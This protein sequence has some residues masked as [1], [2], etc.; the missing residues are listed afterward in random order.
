MLISKNLKPALLALA[1]F[2][3][4]I[5]SF[6]QVRGVIG[7]EASERI[8]QTLDRTAIEG[9]YLQSLNGVAAR[10]RQYVIDQIESIRAAVIDFTNDFNTNP[11]GLRAFSRAAKINPAPNNKNLPSHEEFAIAVDNFTARLSNLRLKLDTIDAIFNSLPSKIE[12]KDMRGTRD[13][14]VGDTPVQLE[15]NMSKVKET[16]AQSLTDLEEQAKNLF[17]VVIVNNA[18]GKSPSQAQPVIIQA[19]TGKS[20]T[21]ETDLILISED[22]RKALRA[23]IRMLRSW[24]TDDRNAFNQFTEF[25]AN[26][27]TRF[28]TK[29]GTEES[30]RFRNDADMKLREEIMGSL[31]KSFF[32]RSRYRAL[33]GLP[34]GG[35]GFNFKKMIGNIEIFLASSDYL[36]EIKVPVWMDSANQDWIGYRQSAENA[37]QVL[38]KRTG[39]VFKPKDGSF[40]SGANAFMT[41]VRGQSQLAEA[42]KMIIEQLAADMYEEVMVA[43][44]DQIGMEDFYKSRWRKSDVEKAAVKQMVEQLDAAKE[45]GALSGTLAGYYSELGDVVDDK[46]VNKDIALKKDAYLK[47][48]T[49][50]E[51]SPSMKAL[52]AKKARLDD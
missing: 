33:S 37:M 14:A 8:I 9:Y 23:E 34:I 12:R 52:K 16:F 1:I 4:P 38:A 51:D 10:D 35:I 13:A 25:T 44:G 27:L 50:V 21:L 28:K 45:N 24:S 46:Q 41:L 6:A 30:Y 39:G 15:A 2:S 40:L 36:K 5:A 11:K 42:N 48:I 17:Q 32:V 43:E 26:Q 29:F 20:L 7:V 47:L 49:K 18:D 3:S 31:I 19:G 22:A